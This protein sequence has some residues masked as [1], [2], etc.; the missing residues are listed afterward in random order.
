MNRFVTAGA[1]VLG[2]AAHPGLA[3]TAQGQTSE[4]Q[5]GQVRNGQA[6][7]EIVDADF[8]QQLRQDNQKR[9]NFPGPVLRDLRELRDAAMTLS[10]Y[11]KEEACQQVAEAIRDLSGNPQAAM[12]ARRARALPVQEGRSA[13]A[14]ARPRQRSFSEAVALGDLASRVRAEQLMGADI[15]DSENDQVGEIT[16]IVFSPKGDPAYAVVAYGGFLG[17]GEE[18]SA[19]PF[20]MLRVSPDGA[21]LY[22]PFTK[23]ALEEAPRFRR[24]SFN[25]VDNENW[26][27]FND[28]YFASV[29]N[30]G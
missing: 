9:A 25:W 29:R 18:A 3:Q 5:T 19:V 15:R 30:R 12:E 28:D 17:M 1:L 14:M 10:M 22:L 8:E 6:R 24:G 21:V 7:C 4:T 13:E 2:L 11:G 16:D 23:D 26:R 27:N 20:D